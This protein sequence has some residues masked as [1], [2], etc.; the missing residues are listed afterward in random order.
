MAS[1]TPNMVSVLIEKTKRREHAERCR[2]KTTGTAMV[3][4]SV[5]RNLAGTNT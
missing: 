1:T 2:S 4:I 5:A 3:G